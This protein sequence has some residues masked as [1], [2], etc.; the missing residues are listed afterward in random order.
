MNVMDRL[1]E[2]Q[3][4]H[5]EQLTEI[6][7]LIL[8]CSNKTQQLFAAA[9]LHELKNGRTYGDAKDLTELTRKSV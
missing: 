2:K 3:R 8:N 6:E 1:L 5:R 7:K 9:E 4:L